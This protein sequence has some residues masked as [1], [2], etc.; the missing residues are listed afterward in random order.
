MRGPPPRLVRTGGHRARRM[1]VSRTIDDAS[2]AAIDLS[3]DVPELAPEDRAS[4]YEP[5]AVT[6]KYAPARATIHPNGELGWIRRLLPLARPQ[7]PIVLVAF[8]AAAA[9]M[10]IQV[11]TPKVTGAAFDSLLKGDD[12]LVQ[13]ATELLVL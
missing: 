3:S 4:P 2:T 13:Y 12:K 7:L 5:M 11:Q 8:V 6:A 9:S 1:S 10:F